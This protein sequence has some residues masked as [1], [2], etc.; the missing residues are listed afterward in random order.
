M[1][2]LVI[3]D[4]Q[5]RDGVCTRHIAAAGN[6][7]VRHRPDVV[8]VLGDWW[9]LP[10]LSRFNSN[11]MAE[12]GR[13]LED[14]N[15]GSSAMHKFMKPLVKLNNQQ[16]RNKKKVYQPHLIYL[17]GNHDPQ[18]R[19]PR[20]V[21]EHPIL[22]GVIENNT[23]HL[24]T[25]Y[26]FEVFDFLEIVEVAG[27]RFSHFFVNPHS[28]KK[29]PLGGMIDTMLKNCGFSFVQGHSQT[30]KMGKHYLADGS[31]RIGIVAGAFYSHEERYMGIQGNRHWRGIIQ[32]NEASNGAAD[33]CEISL[34]YLVRKYL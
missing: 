2:I 1:K 22:E 13:L 24:L 25:G 11:L 19:I 20:L 16:R 33:V 15:A 6:Y 5:V 28:A 21:E 27:I 31:V 8:V 26:G 32:L 30:Y 14:L 9:D 10:S 3:P 12:G 7:L 18:V 29:S 4:T 23:H 17:V 34:D